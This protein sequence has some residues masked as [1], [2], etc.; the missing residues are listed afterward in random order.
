MFKVRDTITVAMAEPQSLPHVDRL[1]QLTGCKIRPILGL[2]NCGLGEL[3]V[4][5]A[6]HVSGRGGLV[7]PPIGS[8]GAAVEPLSDLREEAL[9]RLVAAELASCLR[10]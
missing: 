5:R 6:D 9:V 3:R 1:S 4:G 2:A 10:E 8:F 7:V